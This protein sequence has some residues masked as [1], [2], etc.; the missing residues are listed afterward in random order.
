ME[1]Q[2]QYKGCCVAI[3]FIR[4]D[5][6]FHILATLNNNDELINDPAFASI[7]AGLRDR[8]AKE[9]GEAVIV[10]NRQDAPD[11]VYLDEEGE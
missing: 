9:T 1:N 3:G 6:T 4:Y 7:C 5:D 11:Y 8:L 10:L 2:E